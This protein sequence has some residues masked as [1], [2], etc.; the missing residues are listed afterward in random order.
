VGAVLTGAHDPVDLVGGWVVAGDGLGGLGS[1]PD[2]AELV[3][4]AVGAGEGAEIDGRQRHPGD[5]VDDGEGV[6]GAE[7]VIRN[8]GCF[9]I[10]GGDDFVGVVTD[11]DAGDDVQVGG[12]DDGEG[13]VLLGEGEERRCWSG[14]GRGLCGG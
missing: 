8:V 3:V 11:G 6:E 1:E 5:E 13:V 2:L 10:G 12:I 7:A 14:P 4:E 9:A